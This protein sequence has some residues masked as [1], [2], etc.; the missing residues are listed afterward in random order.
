MDTKNKTS[1]LLVSG[2]LI[3]VFCFVCS[4]FWRT[5][6]VYAMPTPIPE[7]HKEIAVGSRIELPD[8]SI[9]VSGKP[10]LLHFFNP[11]CPCSR[12]NIKHFKSLVA[13]YGD[14][15]DFAIVVETNDITLTEEDIRN[16][17]EIDLPIY[18]DQE[19]AKACGVISTPQAVILD[20]NARLFYRGN[21]NKS[22]Y[23]TD[24]KSDYARMAIDSLLAETPKARFDANAL[25]AYGCSLPSDATCKKN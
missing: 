7:Q 3:A 20:K 1:Y 10:K 15:M 8:P 4:V 25:V 13:K 5:E 22:R 6:V 9:S 17:F 24:A 18:F 21:Y 16:R 11:D 14:Q 19:I 23:C 2:W 12:F